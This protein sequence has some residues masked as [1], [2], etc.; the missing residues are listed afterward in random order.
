[1]TKQTKYAAPSPETPEEQRDRLIEALRRGYRLGG[2]TQAEV[3]D[4]RAQLK[5]LEKANAK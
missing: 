5:Q 1:M 4:L 3:N 2:M